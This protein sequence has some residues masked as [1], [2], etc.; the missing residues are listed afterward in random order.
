[1]Q[2]RGYLDAITFLSK[3]VRVDPDRI[4]VWGD[5]LSAG[6]ACVAAAIDERI[7]AVVAQVPA[8]GPGEPAANSDGKL[9]EAL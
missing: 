3:L 6:V 8:F 4:A 5:N 7:G 1:V 2:A 9:F